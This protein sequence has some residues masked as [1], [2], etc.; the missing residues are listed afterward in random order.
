MLCV[1]RGGGRKHQRFFLFSSSS[2]GALIDSSWFLEVKGGGCQK[3]CW[4]ERTR[5]VIA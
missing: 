1:Q 3:K 5:T 4:K 2:M